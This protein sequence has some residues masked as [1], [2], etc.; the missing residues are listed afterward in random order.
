MKRQTILTAM[1]A[2]VLIATSARALAQI[3][4]AYATKD[5][6]TGATVKVFRTPTGTR[7]DL[8]S[9]TVS[10]TKQLTTARAIVTTVHD[11]RESI[12]IEV[13][14]TGM[15]VTS[16][17][18]QILAATGNSAA[19]ERARA[20]VAQSPLSKKVAELIGKMDLGMA[21]P[22]TPLLLTTRAFFLSA[23]RDASGVRDLNT[24]MRSRPRPDV[25]RVSLPIAPQKSSTQC[26]DEYSNELLAAYDQ[27]D[28]CM[29]HIK[30]WDP[31]FPIERCEVTYETRILGAFAGWMHCLGLTDAV[32]Y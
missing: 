3:A 31:F 26:Y 10:L 18:G 23:N 17:R 16:A 22:M 27:F 21:S 24:W 32:T 2:M 29:K 20:L 28:D 30:W 8:D 6:S 4:P 1:V 11:S 25:V 7:I 13:N 12:R 5:R 14:E 9:P 15:Q 19:A